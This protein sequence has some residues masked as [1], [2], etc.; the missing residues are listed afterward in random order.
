MLRE[1]VAVPEAAAK[2]MEHG[3]VQDS[4]QDAGDSICRRP[5]PRKKLVGDALVHVN[6]FEESLEV[7]ERRA[8]AHKD[9]AGAT[10]RGRH[11]RAGAYGWGYRQTRDEM[12]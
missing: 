5:I 4:I 3:Y 1:S 12:R 6:L 11:V 8:A 7:V 9:L 10:A 2:A